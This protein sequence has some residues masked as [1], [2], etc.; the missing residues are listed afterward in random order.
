MP[1]KAAPAKKAQIHIASDSTR[2][3]AAERGMTSERIAADLA[4]FQNGGGRIEVLGT[5]RVLTPSELATQNKVI[6]AES[7]AAARKTHA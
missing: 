1:R 2:N 5:T 7:K 3:P 4:Q 6:A